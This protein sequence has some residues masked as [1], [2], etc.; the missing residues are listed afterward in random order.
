MPP[1]VISVGAVRNWSTISLSGVVIFAAAADTASRAALHTL[2]TTGGSGIPAR[3][4][5]P[6]ALPAYRVDQEDRD[7]R[8]ADHQIRAA[9]DI[10]PGQPG[11][12][13]GTRDRPARRGGVTGL[14]ALRDRNKSLTAR[15]GDRAQDPGIAATAVLR[16]QSRLDPERVA[17]ANADFHEEISNVYLQAV[18]E[19]PANG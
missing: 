7:R 3:A 6:A 5:E 10:T 4:E 19:R 11:H 13:R 2:I 16:S 8:P 17:T 15:A 9:R 12:P 18:G 14:V 1:Y